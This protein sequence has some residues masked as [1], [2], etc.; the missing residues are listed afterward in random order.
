MRPF[1]TN[2]RHVACEGGTLLLA[3]FV[4]VLGGCDP[5]SNLMGFN[6]KSTDYAEEPGAYYDTASPSFDDDS[7]E[8]DTDP[9]ETEE[10]PLLYRPAV[11]DQYLFVVNADRN[12]ITR[13]NVES[14]AVD[15][16][17]VGKVPTTVE[18]TVDGSRAVI[19]N[20]GDDTLAVVQAEDLSVAIVPLRDGMNRLS[21]AES[22]EWAMTWY[23]DSWPSSGTWAGVISFNEVSFARLD[24]AVHVPLVVGFRPHGVEWS[25]DGDRAVVV[26]DTVLAVVDLTMDNP[27]A[28]M[29]SITDEQDDPPAAEEVILSPDGQYAIV[30]Q[31][32][33]N[34]LLV[35]DL[36]DGE[37]TTLALQGTPTDMDVDPTGTRLAVLVRARQEIYEFDLADVLAA[38]TL[39]TLDTEDEYGSLAYCGPDGLAALFTNA[40]LTPK[41]AI[42]NAATGDVTEK[43]LVKPVAT[44]GAIEAKSSALVFHTEDNQ[45]DIEDEDPFYNAWGITLLDLE[46]MQATPLLLAGETE[47]WGATDD[48]D[49]AFVG[50]ADKPLLEV[51]DLSSHLPYEVQLS[52]IPSNVGALPGR[53]VGYASMEHDLGRIGFYDTESGDL[54]TLTGFELNSEIEH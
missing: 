13:V 21:L 37:R 44:V 50:L 16:V 6:D 10:S 33:A 25:D 45:N 49:W 9:P 28:T 32:G 24:D 20:E 42:W 26:S 53:A 8:A 5:E 11:T 12:T 39:T 41:M 54:D 3:G 1:P 18:T 43:T 4:S 40:T 34:G 23:D 36:T 15:T 17:A 52:S 38:P 35:V 48:G 31:F 22:G 2:V 7:G 14:L 47:A 29:L 30:R 46:T 51:L 27:T 19:L